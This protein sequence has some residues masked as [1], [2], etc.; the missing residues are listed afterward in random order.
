[1]LT[2]IPSVNLVSN[3]GFHSGATHTTN[4]YSSH[5]KAKSFEI[6]LPLVHPKFV[7][8]NK[9][10]DDKTIELEFVPSLRRR[11]VYRISKLRRKLN[12]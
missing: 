7:I 8:H 1:M 10:L 4:I 3:H 6:N 11:V 9:L 5:N 12:I 2:I